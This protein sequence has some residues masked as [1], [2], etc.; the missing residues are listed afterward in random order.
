MGQDEIKV[1]LIGGWIF[2]ASVTMCNLEHSTL[3]EETTVQ[4]GV[5]ILFHLLLSSYLCSQS[6]RTLEKCKVKAGPLLTLFF[7]SANLV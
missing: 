3:K 2:R 7:L 4:K 6:L 1:Y 5:D